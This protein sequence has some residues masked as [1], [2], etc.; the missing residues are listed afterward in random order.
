MPQVRM[1]REGDDD[2]ELWEQLLLDE[3]DVGAPGAP[4]AAPGGQAQPAFGLP[5]FLEHIAAEAAAA[6][7]G[8]RA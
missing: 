8:S 6:L 1:L 2:A 7:G 5:Q 3:P 4:G